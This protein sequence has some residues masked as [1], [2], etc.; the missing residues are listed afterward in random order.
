MRDWKRGMRGDLK[1]E[2]GL[3]WKDRIYRKEGEVLRGM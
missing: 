3:C 1:F 2:E